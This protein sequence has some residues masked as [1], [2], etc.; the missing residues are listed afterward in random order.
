MRRKFYDLYQAHASPIAEEALRRIGVLYEIEEQIRG[1]PSDQRQQ[2]RQQRARPLTDSLH[3][4]LKQCLVK[5]FKKSDVA[6]AIQYAL[7]RW[8]S[9]LRYIGDGRLEIDNN[10]AERAL[11]AVALGRK[12]Y[13]FQGSDAGGE[14]AAAM[15]SLIGTA[16][17]NDLDPEAYLSYVLSH[18]ADHPV[19][20]LEE[21][22]PWNAPPLERSR[23]QNQS[24]RGI[25]LTR[26][27]SCPRCRRRGHD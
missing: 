25:R 20:R 17:L 13:L 5:L 15:Y 4:W 8:T 11:R 9:L 1:R 7:D 24:S 16:K 21:L 14:Y 6:M 22:L 26:H 12:N 3:V 2:I 23:S 10:A 18:I 27:Q 19:H